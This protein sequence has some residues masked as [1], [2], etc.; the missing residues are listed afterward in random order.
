MDKQTVATASGK[1][2]T[3]RVARVGTNHGYCGQLVARNGR[4]VW[5]GDVLPFAA[6]AMDSAISSASRMA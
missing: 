3:A 6:A 4:V 5:E 1:I 2:L